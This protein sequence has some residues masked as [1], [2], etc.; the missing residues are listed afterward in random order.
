MVR[1]PAQANRR[2]L[3]LWF[4]SIAAATLLMVVLGGITRLTQS[5]LSIV[6]WRPIM[7]TLPPMNEAQWLDA[8]DRYRQF[9]EYLQLRRGMTLA[10]FKVI[11]FWEYF[12]RL[13]ARLLGVLFLVPWI[14]FWRRGCLT[15]P[16]LTRTSM[17]FALGAMQGVM[18]WIMVR[19]GL[20]DRPSVSHYRLAAH[21]ALAFIILGWSV[22]LARDVADGAPAPAAAD[23]RRVMLRGLKWMGTL[24]AVQILWGA[25]VAGLKA[26]YIFNTFPLMG[27]QVLPP[28]GLALDPAILNLVQNMPTVQWIHRLLG[29]LVLAAAAIFYLRVHRVAPDAWFRRLNTVLLLLVCGQYLLG[30]LTLLLHVPIAIAVIHQTTAGLIVAVWVAW[31][32]D[33]KAQ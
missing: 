5:G 17:L 22:W 24:L 33:A 15:R 1:S 12:H 32:H 14:I 2:H 3:R 10:Q 21:L 8:F 9:P 18:G 4:W 7:G 31:V 25:L 13:V 29:T 19:S 28:S 26:G 30:V 16:L 23:E 27:G 20:V 6:N 11:F